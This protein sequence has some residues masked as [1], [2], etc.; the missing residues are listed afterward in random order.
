[1]FFLEGTG[2]GQYRMRTRYPIGSIPP[3]SAWLFARYARRLRVKLTL[4][5]R[6]VRSRKFIWEANNDRQTPA[7]S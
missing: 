3:D 4:V 5:A 7:I 6:R 2:L 1:M